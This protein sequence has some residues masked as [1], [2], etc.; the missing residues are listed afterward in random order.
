ML[1][2]GTDAAWLTWF[3]QAGL[4]RRLSGVLGT[5]DADAILAALEVCFAPGMVSPQSLAEAVHSQG[6]DLE[7]PFTRALL[8]D[9][10]QMA[11]NQHLNDAFLRARQLGLSRAWV[12]A[13]LG[14]DPLA[15]DDELDGLISFTHALGTALM[16]LPEDRAVTFVLETCLPEGPGRTI[17]DHYRTNG[18]PLAH[19]N[20]AALASCGLGDNSYAGVFDNRW[21]GAFTWALTSTLSQWDVVVSNAGRYF[22]P[23]YN[24]LLEVSGR[25]MRMMGFAEQEPAMWAQPWAREWPVFGRGE[26]KEQIEEVALLRRVKVKEQIDPGG[27]GH[28]WVIADNATGGLGSSNVLGYLVSVAGVNPN[29]TVDGLQ[30]QVNRDYWLWKD[31]AFPTGDFFLRRPP[32]AP[33]PSEDTLQKWLELNVSGS[34]ATK[35]CYLQGQ[36]QA[37]P[38]GPPAAP[39][40]AGHVVKIGSSILAFMQ[41]LGSN[42][43]ARTW[44]R[45]NNAP[46]NNQRVALMASGPIAPA[47]GVVVEYL[48]QGG[49]PSVTWA[50]APV[51][52]VPQT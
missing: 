35:I 4:L 36:F 21:H 22:K 5:R 49:P 38:G 12:E 40:G 26:W 17:R 32:T 42:D 28:I 37:P 15:Q 23:D 7:D 13:A 51:N 34:F 18:M 24:R 25:L 50:D 14:E 2:P 30:L 20:V 27:S 19:G 43:L 9:L 3:T 8:R 11:G 46:L 33:S 1:D 47:S 48:W 39:S 52:D 10:V 31:A 45:T 41:K 44:R 6:C 29:T 16:P